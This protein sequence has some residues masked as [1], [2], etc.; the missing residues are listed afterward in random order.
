MAQEEKKVRGRFLSNTGD[1]FVLI[2]LV[3]M[4]LLTLLINGLGVAGLRLVSTEVYVF[5]PLLIALTAA[6]WGVSGIIRVIHRP[7]LK[8]VVTVVLVI[9]MIG[10][11]LLGMQYGS[12]VAG[13]TLPQRYAVMTSPNGQHRLIV[14]RQLDTDEGRVD[15]RRAARLAEHPDSSQEYVAEDWGFV[16]TAYATGTMGMFYRPDTLIEGEVYIG[17]ASQGELMLEWEDDETVGHF[18]VQNPGPGDGGEMRASSVP[19]ES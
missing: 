18:Y 2:A 1:R 7:V 3:V 6:G 12:F 9:I 13:L 11:V 10:L 8:R 16:Y 4:V 5:L 17:A 14:M 19:K 15:A